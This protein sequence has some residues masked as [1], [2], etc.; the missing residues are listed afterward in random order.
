MRTRPAIGSTAMPPDDAQDEARGVV[1]Q[2]AA[3]PAATAVPPLQRPDEGSPLGRLMRGKKRIADSRPARFLSR[4]I[5]VNTALFHSSRNGRPLDPANFNE[6]SVSANDVREGADASLQRQAQLRAEALQ[7]AVSPDKKMD[8]L[9]QKARAVAVQSEWIGGVSDKQKTDRRPSL[10]TTLSPKRLASAVQR[11]IQPSP[12]DEPDAATG[13]ASEQIALGPRDAL[14]D[15]SPAHA[16]AA[17]HS[18]DA[19]TRWITLALPP[20]AHGEAHNARRADG[21]ALAATLPDLDQLQADRAASERLRHVLRALGP[22]SSPIARESGVLTVQTL[23]RLGIAD[24][25]EAAAVLEAVRNLDFEDPSRMPAATPDAAAAWRVARAMAQTTPGFDA[26]MQLRGERRARNPLGDLIDVPTAQAHRRDAQRIMLQ[27]AERLEPEDALPLRAARADGTARRAGG[28]LDPA[29]AGPRPDPSPAAVI[30]RHRAAGIGDPAHPDMARWREAPLAWR[31]GEAA[32]AML[33]ANGSAALLHPDAVGDFVAWQHG[34]R[35]DGPGS[36]YALTRGRLHKFTAKTIP[37]AAQSQSK[38]FIP[39]LFGKRRSPLSA[40]PRFGTQGVPRK[41]IKV[42]HE[43]LKAGIDAVIATLPEAVAV[44]ARRALPAMPA[45]AA[46]A[47][48]QDWADRAGTHATPAF[49]DAL[50]RVRT[51]AHPGEMAAPPVPLGIA[52]PAIDAGN[53]NAADANAQAADEHQMLTADDPVSLARRT[54]QAVARALPSSSRLRLAD[55]HRVGFSTRGLSA[56]VSTALGLVGIPVSP[57]LDLRASRQ[58]EA[59]V[60][61]ARNTQG[62]DVFIG[63]TDTTTTHAAAGV[64]VGYDVDVGLAQFR[65]GV[66]VQGTAH[67]DARQRPRGAMLR[68]ARRVDANGNRYNDAPMLQ[69]AEQLVSHLFDESLRLNG[70]APLDGAAAD[71]GS[72]AHASWNRLAGHVID[73]PDISLGWVDGRSGQEKHG[74][75]VDISPSF[76]MFG[77]ASWLR[78][79]TNAGAAYEYTSRRW[80]HGDEHSGRMQVTQHRIGSGHRLIGRLGGVIG[81]TSE[82]SGGTGEAIGIGVVSLDAPSLNVAYRDRSRQAKVQLVRENGRL[83]SRACLVDLEYTD[84]KTYCM[85]MKRQRARWISYY[86]SQA[87]PG[88]PPDIAHTQ[89]ARRFEQHLADVVKNSLPNQTHFHRWRLRRDKAEEIDG[90]S[91]MATQALAEALAIEK[92]TQRPANGRL[93]RRAPP[94]PRFIAA[95]EAHNAFQDAINALVDDPD[96]WI[97]IEEKGKERS[98]QSRSPGVNFAL[99]WN[100]TTSAAGERELFSEAASFS[101]QERLDPTRRHARPADPP[102]V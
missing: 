90:L 2:R 53:A 61:M 28:I 14:P 56:N 83:V 49:Q 10:A 46:I 40:L 15:R 62:V 74:V 41:A 12:R 59:V 29:A 69:K 18:A 47:T 80:L 32:L 38:N 39:R 98:R 77:P 5:E 79:G 50:T 63:T 8:K 23:H 82:A 101:A 21:G 16:I 97:P 65:A 99:Q 81:G 20:R 42:E 54:L 72:D 95:Q 26:L 33:R 17:L 55:G 67:S 9:A 96:S 13:A 89:A 48:L 68:V 45:D 78:L 22:P 11:A 87:A 35:E 66:T 43:A 70:Q 31:S 76:R 88:T 27:V 91:A 60:E 44:E 102:R 30:A 85:A 37:R 24:A 84:V 57:R 100:T 3:R 25:E 93:Q 4:S 71:A 1:P 75:S 34:F 64:L 73:D 6:G 7:D 92:G 58:R 94:D 52:R 36:D 19:W 86:A 51:L